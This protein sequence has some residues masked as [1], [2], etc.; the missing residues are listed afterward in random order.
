[1]LAVNVCIARAMYATPE[2]TLQFWRM[3]GGREIFRGF[4]YALFDS[5]W[6]RVTV[7]CWMSRG[8]FTYPRGTAACGRDT[9]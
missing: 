9:S 6:G 1:M 7:C 4:P 5:T 8:T 3:I 2:N